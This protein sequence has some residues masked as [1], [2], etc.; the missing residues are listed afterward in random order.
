[1]SEAGRLFRNA[2]ELDPNFAHAHVGLADV[3]MMTV[4][5][6][7]A[8]VAVEK[9]LELDPDLAE[10]HASLGFIRMFHD[11]KWAEAESAFVRSIELNPNYAMAHHWYA[12][13]LAV[14]GRNGEAKSEMLRALEINPLSHNFL[15]DLGQIY[16]FNREYK[17]AEQ[18][19]L[20]ALEIYP[21]FVFA[22]G[23]L[24]DTY[25]K[26]G[27]YDKAVEAIINAEKINSAFANQTTERQKERDAYSESRRKTYRAGGIGKFLEDSFGKSHDPDAPIG[28]ARIYALLGENEKALDNLERAYEGKAFLSIFVKADP[29][30]D[31][32]RSNPRYE[33]I[34]RRMNL[35]E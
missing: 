18:W 7:G 32:L 31:D 33:E 3:L 22:N 8:K 5:G 10:A 2:I 29:I 9:A 14:K 20:K 4:Q 15:A 27:E 28:N 16:Y 12:Q 13:L 11:W 19:C 23:C 21:D 17:E 25:L 35:S 26:T 24:K 34:L 1:M 30:F 6:T